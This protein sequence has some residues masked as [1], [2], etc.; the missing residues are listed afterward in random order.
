MTP[1]NLSGTL[2][3]L[4]VYD[5]EKDADLITGWNQNSQYQRLL[6][7]GPGNLFPPKQIRDFLEAEIGGMH[8]FSIH[9]LAEDRVIGFLDLAGFDWISR[10]AWVGIGIGDEAYWGK[11]YGTDAMRILLRYAFTALNLHRVN[12]NVFGYNERA[13]RSYLK[14][15]FV[16]EGRQ[17]QL[18]NRGD[19]RW[20]VIYMGI[21]KKEWEA[22][23]SK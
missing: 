2:V 9:T 12:L 19:Q 7:S 5:P 16:E 21:L 11:G 10:S 8:F 3:R 15:G 17:R 18:L 14:C 4:C 13:V 1:F 23:S 22:Q 20:D 6:D